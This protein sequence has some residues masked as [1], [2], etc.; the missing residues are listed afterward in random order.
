MSAGLPTRDALLTAWARLVTRR[1][2]TTIIVCLVLALASAGNTAARLHFNSDRS[3]LIDPELPFQQRYAEFKRQFPRWDDAVVVVERGATPESRDAAERFIAALE[4]RLAA[5]PRFPEFTSGVPREEAPV[6]LLLTE[7]IERVRS[8]VAEI[9]RTG[10]VLGAPSL[11]ALLGLSMLGSNLGPAEREGLAGLLERTA[12]VGT[13]QSD[14]VLGMEQARGVERLISGSGGLAMVL[15]SVHQE[16]VD[17]VDG[18]IDTAAAVN[19]LAKG[20]SG[21][22]EILAELRA[23]PAHAGVRAGVTG[24]PVLES[25]ET[26][27]SQK[28]AALAGSISLVAITVLMLVVYRGAVVP[29]LAMASLLVG[30]A[31]S[32]GWATL[33]VGHLQLLSVT[34]ASLLLGLG[35][36][37]AIHIIAR[38]ELLHADHEHL[39]PAIEDTY[40]GVG[41]GII[42]ASATVAAAALAMSLT[43]FSGVAEMGVIAAGGMVLCTIAIMCVLPAALM[44]ITRPSERLRTRAGGASRPFMGRAGVAFHRQP[45]LVMTGAVALSLVSV[46]LARGVIFDSDLQRL[47][48]SGTES[49]AWQNAIERDDQKSVWHAVVLARSNDE[50]RELSATLRAVPQVSDVAGAGMLFQD[51]AQVA[52]KQAELAKLPP[53]SELIDT[54]RA[55][56]DRHD[57]AAPARLIAAAQ[58]LATRWND[59]DARLAS[60]AKAV[61]SLT[62]EQ[63][64]A[65]LRAYKADRLDLLT[66]IEALRTAQSATPDQ[67]PAAL[68]PLMIGR[69]GSLLLRVYPRDPG[70][71]QSVLSPERLNAFVPAVLAAA[72]NA[73]GPAVQIYES[74]RLITGAYRQAALYALVAIVALLVIDFGI[75][76]GGWLDVL[77]ALLPVALGVV[78][79]LA[80][81]RLANVELNFANM[82]VMPLIIGIGVGCGVHAVRRWR[83]QPLDEPPGLAGG[84]GRAITLTTLTTVIGFAAMMSGQHRGI[85]SLGFVM[86]VGLTAVWV[87]TIF[88]VPS[89]LQL[90][91][92]A[93]A[94]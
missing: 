15:V 85:W 45:A 84:S 87:A 91:R 31:W 12:A 3:D 5:D 6:G 79:M 40:R 14:S 28:D 82:I 17:G 41:P 55:D 63:A 25:D 69:D 70:T 72:P 34:F 57:D 62:S 73:A 50:A 32:F 67:L 42:T 38:L 71:G 13:G 47:M 64:R 81:M 88:V 83:L 23:D 61:A 9:S 18:A 54:A 90:R 58:R 68:R 30:M 89:V 21:L 1:P 7:P 20:I 56:L 19:T 33:A 51:P 29:L 65:A 53:T 37:V 8:V 22:R 52:Q 24:V 94:R 27:Q 80:V 75:R 76:R 92:A 44:L 86:S 48:P 2:W 4:K 11:D 59:T 74:T 10:P 46:W 36:D 78:M 77:C 35:I 93:G 39:G 43:S 49:V 66:R 26:A 60:A 16:R